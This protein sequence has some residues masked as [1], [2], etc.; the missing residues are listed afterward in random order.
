[1]SQI[2]FETGFK[3]SN[4]LS[5]DNVLSVTGFEQLLLAERLVSVVAVIGDV[6]QEILVKG[7]GGGESREAVG[8]EEPAPLAVLLVVVLPRL[9][10]RFNKIVSSLVK[11]LVTYLNTRIQQILHSYHL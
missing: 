10:N 5:N 9:R 8:H 1:M 6:L 3:L 11:I 2:L 7:P 4:C